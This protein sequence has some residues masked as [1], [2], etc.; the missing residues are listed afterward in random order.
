MDKLFDILRTYK[1]SLEAENA[2][3]T[4]LHLTVTPEGADALFALERW[5]RARSVDAIEREIGA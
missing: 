3:R 1:A 4:P 5:L 2:M